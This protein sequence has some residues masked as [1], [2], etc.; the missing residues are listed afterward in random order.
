MLIAL[1]LSLAV[2]IPVANYAR[3]GNQPRWISELLENAEPFGHGYGTALIIIAVLVLDPD[4]RRFVPQLLAGSLGA[5]IVANLVKLLVIRI[6]PRDLEVLPATVWETFGGLF[7]MV[8]GN[9]SQS[10]PSAHTATAVGLAV[11]LSASYPRGRWFFTAMAILVGMQRIHCSA[12]FPSDVFAGAVVGWIVA[13]LCLLT[14]AEPS[15][16]QIPTDP[17]SVET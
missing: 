5:G 13:V 3:L 14:Q 8:D 1:L 7:S 11:M 9:R 6:R 17:A 16:P 12:H 15:Q 4:R 10:F 2:D